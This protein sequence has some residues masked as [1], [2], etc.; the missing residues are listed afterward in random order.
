MLA[1]LYSKYNVTAR[2]EFFKFWLV[3]QSDNQGQG[4]LMILLSHVFQG[5]KRV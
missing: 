1:A 2:I 5:D 4:S 3:V